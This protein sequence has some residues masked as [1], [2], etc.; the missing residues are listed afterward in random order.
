[1]GVGT[2]GHDLFKEFTSKIPQSVAAGAGSAEM[3]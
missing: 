2:N 3:L 1:M